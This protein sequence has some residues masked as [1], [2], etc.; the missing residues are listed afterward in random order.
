MAAAAR[1]RAESMVLVHFT[2]VM[3]AKAATHGNHLG[4]LV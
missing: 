1:T 2:D 4:N 3:A